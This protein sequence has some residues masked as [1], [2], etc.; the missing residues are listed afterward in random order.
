MRRA[1]AEPYSMRRAPVPQ[2]DLA[3]RPFTRAEGL[4]LVTPDVLEG[5]GYQR[6]CRGAY[7]IRTGEVTYARRIQTHRCVLPARA[8]LGGWSA[9]HALGVLWVP[10]AAPV[11]IVLPPWERVRR[12]PGLRVRG[13]VLAGGEVVGS[14]LGPATSGPRTAF[15]LARRGSL[16]D[17]VAALDAVLRATGCAPATV[18][19]V[20]RQHPG[21]RGIRMLREA[22]P[23]T[24][25]RAESP[26]ESRLRVMIARAGLP[27]PVPQYEVCDAGRFVARLDLAWPAV[28]AAVEYDGVHHRE[29][30]Q[31]RRDLLRHNRL[32][33]LG[34]VVLRWTPPRWLARTRSSAS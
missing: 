2:S 29:P 23:L 19:E 10:Q 3:A 12:R 30:D 32:R 5:P 1:F 21:V 8:V 4:R 28:R 17:A 26:P 13:D 15:D 31:F 9:A 34:W 6:L 24:D 22:L 18:G 14:P 20:A 33:G 16:P 7:W 27:T 11:E 25:L